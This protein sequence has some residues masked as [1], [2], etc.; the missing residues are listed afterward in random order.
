MVS[1]VKNGLLFWSMLPN[2]WFCRYDT[3]SN[4]LDNNYAHLHTY[5]KTD[6]LL[7]VFNSTIMWD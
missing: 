3:Y 4:D 5:E 2:I 6:F 1:I 7:E